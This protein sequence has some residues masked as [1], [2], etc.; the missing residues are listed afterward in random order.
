MCT[1]LAYFD[2]TGR[3]YVGRTLELEL[4]LPYSLG[5]I[6]A[7]TPFTSQVPSKSPLSWTTRFDVL[8][9]AAPRTPPPPGAAI[10]PRSMVVIDGLNEA[11][12]SLNA[13]A[14]AD[15]GE[16]SDLG[17]PGAVLEA[18]DLGIWALGNFATVAELRTALATQAVN[19]TRMPMAGNV[20]FPVHFMLTDLAGDSVTIEGRNG[21]FAVLDNPVHVMTNG[22]SFDWHLTNLQ[23]WTHLD[24]T[25]HSSADFG[26]L[27]VSQPD[28]GIATTALPGSNTAV[29]RF[30]R[31]VYY[32]K[33]V[34]K[35]TDPDQAVA[36]L[37]A[38]VNNFHRPRGATID[39]PGDGGEGVNFGGGPA[40]TSPTTEYTTHTFMADASRTLYYIRPYTGLNWSVFDMARL[41][42][43]A[44]MLFMPLES[45]D[46]FGGDGTSRLL[47][48]SLDS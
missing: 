27:R 40:P 45:I 5:F 13:N 48:A 7:G 30:I 31:A 21:V 16:T 41:K 36:T 24:N 29:G 28:S 37:A 14:Y 1:A 19:A 4:V 34:E 9:V 46:P 39:L 35:A 3:P 44:E 22:P 15:T 32:G 33:F 42:G 12:L 6:P 2:A 26:S 17:G 25:D 43:A 8:A 11:G 38:I 47:T 20:P 10:D 18:A 23:N